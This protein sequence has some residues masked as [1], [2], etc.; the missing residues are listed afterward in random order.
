MK[1]ADPDGGIVGALPAD[2][3]RRRALHNEVHARPPARIRLPALVVYVAVMH[4]GVDRRQELE[5]LRRL[6]GQEH[7]TEGDLAGNFLRLRCAPGYTLKWERHTEFSRYSV[8]QP[9]PAGAGL[10]V[11]DP[12]LQPHAMLPPGWLAAIPGRTI[13]AIELALVPGDLTDPPTLLE[14]ARAWF[15]ERP[16]VA[17]LLGRDA[18]SMVVTDF[19]LRDDGFE[20][21]LVIAPPT[22][23]ETRAGRISAR[24][25][26]LETY[27]MVALLGL[28]VA[29]AL[30]GPLADA[31][32]R[33][34]RL[35]A[36]MEAKTTP[37]HVLLDELVGLAATVERAIAEHSYRFFATRAYERIVAQRIAELRERAI[38]GT[39]TISEFMQRRLAPAIATVASV[40]QR[41]A[42][43]SERVA[44]TSA[45][46][47][48]QVDIAREDQNRQL[49]E[50]LTRGQALQ[51]RLQTTVEGLS[52]AAIS[53][54]VISLVLYGA[55]AL[56]SA[57][58]PLHPELTAGAL[59]PVVL[60]GVWRL[61]RRIHAK[62]HVD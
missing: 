5:H 1:V 33:L 22:T 10:G 60:W 54:Y 12:D 32:Q 36:A 3:A 42:A 58:V 50:K 26:E 31:E 16:V 38:P 46:L 45:L 2:D 21:M 18:H 7:L 24:L 29:K 15:D 56:K 40:E 41:L 14:Q 23:S 49:L 53:Y 43:L 30:G 9:L 25:L 28:P 62:L 57:G 47:R 55:K 48:T 27:R 61:T 59:M 11:R 8:V 52:I 4:D 37:D 44:R 39:Q 19:W 13:C 51:L 35:A 17:A 6:P 20:R 34:A